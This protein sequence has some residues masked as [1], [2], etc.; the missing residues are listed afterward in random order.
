MLVSQRYITTDTV[1][2][3]TGPAIPPPGFNTNQAKKPL[4][5]DATTTKHAKDESIAKNETMG[6]ELGR[7]GTGTKLGTSD[8]KDPASTLVKAVDTKKGE[9]K[10]T[11]WQKVKHGVQHFWDGTKLLG[12]EIKISSNL[13]LKMGSGYELSRRERRQVRANNFCSKLPPTDMSTY[14]SSE[15]SETSDASSHSRSSLL[16]R[17]ENCSCR[18]P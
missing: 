3:G 8:I 5:R 17:Q 2:S 12:A 6:V 16:S 4:P 14:S 10:T 9:K 15:P 18:S 1:T 13:A 7:S 11:V